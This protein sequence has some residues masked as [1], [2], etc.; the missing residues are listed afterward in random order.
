MQHP[1]GYRLDPGGLLGI[2]SPVE[3]PFGPEGSPHHIE[4]PAS[5][6]YVLIEA[7]SESLRSMITTLM[8]QNKRLQV[9]VADLLIKN[10]CLRA[11]W[12]LKSDCFSRTVCFGDVLASLRIE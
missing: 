9:L 4:E 10:Q 3:A 8:D 6:D 7:D 11:G 5:S 12:A 1:A 2:V